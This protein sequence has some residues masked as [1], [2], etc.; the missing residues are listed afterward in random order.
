MKAAYWQKG[1]ALDYKNS[2]NK[3][4]EAGDVILLG[5]RI[6]VSG[7]D[8]EK[9][10]VGSVSVEGVFRITK[11]DETEIAFGTEVYLSNSGITASAKTGEG[12]DATNNQKAGYAAELSA[13]GNADILVK[14][15]A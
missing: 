12:N 6:G 3:K 14:I 13:A 4:I 2:T 11:A 10:E 15:N 1:E 5:N 7:T 8:I 9:G